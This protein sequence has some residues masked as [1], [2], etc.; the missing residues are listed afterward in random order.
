[1]KTQLGEVFVSSRLPSPS[2]FSASF[3]RA[4]LCWR[5]NTFAFVLVAVALPGS[6]VC[7][8][9]YRVVVGNAAFRVATA[10]IPN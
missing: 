6:S 8:L 10:L 3:S 4:E 1:M 5:R 2:S 9:S 7:C